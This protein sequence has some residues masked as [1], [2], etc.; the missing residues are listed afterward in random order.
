MLVDREAVSADRAL[1][2]GSGGFG[3][4][5]NHTESRGLRLDCNRW[6]GGGSGD[7]EV[8]DSLQGRLSRRREDNTTRS[9]E[10]GV[11]VHEDDVFVFHVRNGDTKRFEASD[12]GLDLVEVDI[13]VL[14]RLVPDVVQ[15]LASGH[16]I[17]HASFLK[18][19]F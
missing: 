1:G 13:D 10:R 2:C 15:L 16:P 9:V 5:G 12:S 7:E 3:L 18:L 17:R 19:A 14:G 6:I 4:A 8:L 11:E